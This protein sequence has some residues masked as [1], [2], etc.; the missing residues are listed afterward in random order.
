MAAR[1]TRRRAVRLPSLEATNSR[2]NFKSGVEKLPFSVVNA[3]LSFW[4]QSDGEWRFAC[5][6]NQP[7]LT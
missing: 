1:D 4:Q 7:G 2:I 6:A 5:E 3:E